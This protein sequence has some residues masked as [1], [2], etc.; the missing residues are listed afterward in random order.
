[1]LSLTGEIKL[2]CLKCGNRTESNP[3]DTCG[4]DIQKEC[5]FLLDK[6]AIG[7]IKIPLG[8]K[9]KNN[10]EYS[11]TTIK[12]H[13]S[14]DLFESDFSLSDND[15]ANTI[16]K[17]S[18]GTKSKPR[19]KKLILIGVSLALVISLFS[20]VLVY[21]NNAKKSAN[22]EI[23]K[24]KII[25][26]GRYEQDGKTENGLEPI[27]WKVSS[28]SFDGKSASLDCC[29][30]LDYLNYS[31]DPNDNMW[32]SSKLRLWL[33]SGFLNTAFS[34]EEQKILELCN[35]PT[36]HLY[37]ENDDTQN[38]IN[39]YTSDKVTINE[40]SIVDNYTEFP[41]ISEY[42]ESRWNE[43]R[44]YNP[45]M[46]VR[47]PIRDENVLA[48]QKSDSSNKIVDIWDLDMTDD[49]FVLPH[50]CINIEKY[51]SLVN[52]DSDNSSTEI[53]SN[54]GSEKETDNKSKIESTTQKSTE[55]GGEQIVGE[56]PK[57][58]DI[59]YIS[60]Q[61][62]ST[63]LYNSPSADDWTFTSLTPCWVK[64]L[65]TSIVEGVVWLQIET[66]EYVQIN[67]DDEKRKGWIVQPDVYLRE[68]AE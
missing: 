13:D 57:I 15:S 52:K 26:L 62:S 49:A 45:I 38:A 14:D 34:E 30:C 56:T 25:K 51:Y 16:K 27:E 4:F 1:M 44:K 41:A 2:N 7:K 19:I 9:E 42:A 3:C 17:G 31:D 61:I 50:I 67:T 66:V 21:F 22:N 40:F 11:E 5:L 53:S 8:E 36:N 64:V 18:G 65:S 48:I 46:W 12:S 6:D 39:E 47:N 63:A 28:L 35:D 20:F 10:F 43:K 68:P 24:G 37:A 33:N 59:I 58:G 54:T 32:K 55:R 23:A 60:P 29:Y